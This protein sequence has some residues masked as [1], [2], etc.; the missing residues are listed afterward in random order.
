MT[1]RPSRLRLNAQIAAV[2]RLAGHP[3]TYRQWVSASAVQDSEWGFNE[4]N[5]YSDIAFQGFIRFQNAMNAQAAVGQIINQNITLTTDFP[6]R[7]T[8]SEIHWQGRIYR[9]VSESVPSRVGG[10]WV[11]QLARGRMESNGSG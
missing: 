1:Y 3:M 4:Q 7:D 11:T 2:K 9:P 6:I 8:R 10:Q 5:Y